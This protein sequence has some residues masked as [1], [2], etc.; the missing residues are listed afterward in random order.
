MI[1]YNLNII[2]EM[3]PIYGD[4]LCILNIMIVIMIYDIIDEKKKHAAP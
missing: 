1:A 3:I 2:I 4:G